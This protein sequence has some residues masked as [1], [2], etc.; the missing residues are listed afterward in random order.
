MTVAEMMAEQ[1]R[2]ADAQKAA[3]KRPPEAPAPKPSIPR[4]PTMAEMEQA[5][6]DDRTYDGKA[7]EGSLSSIIRK[8]NPN[9]FIGRDGEKT[10][11]PWRYL[12]MRD[13][14]LPDSGNPYRPSKEDE[15]EKKPVATHIADLDYDPWSRPSGYDN[16]EPAATATV[17]S[18]QA[19]VSAVNTAP[20]ASGDMSWDDWLAPVTKEPAEQVVTE[21]EMGTLDVMRNLRK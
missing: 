8:E 16:N 4:K 12:S 7:P 3:K 14:E 10:F 13:I 15:N 21:S 2:V 6:R 19:S 18:K 17:A 20:P 9:E 5:Y 1:R 11:V